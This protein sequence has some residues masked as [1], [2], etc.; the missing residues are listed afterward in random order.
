MQKTKEIL[1]EMGLTNT[2]INIYLSL[3]ELGPSTINPIAKRNKLQSSST[4]YCLNSLTE[5]GFVSYTTKN[6]R[7]HY[8]AI[9]PK[10]LS[11]IIDHKVKKLET[12]KNYLKR[13]LPELN[14]LKALSK[15]EHSAKLYEG[16]AGI[17]AVFG[18]VIESLKKG[19]EYY[20]FY[21]SEEPNDLEISEFFKIFNR[22]LKTKGI[23][24][25]L[26]AKQNYKKVFTKKYGSRFLKTYQE[27]RYT[28]ENIP[29][30]T[31]IF[32]DNIAFFIWNKNPY[33]FTIKSPE[34]AEAYRKHFLSLWKKAKP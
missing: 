5:K 17:K 31:T 20:S 12:Q 25:K 18:Q 7:K 30:G 22:R 23:K 9:N 15:P 24:L 27:I 34:M 33:A 3:L 1:K 4:F 13:S 10:S 8:E 19:E 14:A 11:S 28:K 26:L 29:I 21:M 32:K 16:F 2:E 6:N